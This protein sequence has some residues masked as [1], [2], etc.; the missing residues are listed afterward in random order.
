MLNNWINSTATQMLSKNNQFI[1]NTLTTKTQKNAYNLYYELKNVH[2]LYF[3]DKKINMFLVSV[4]LPYG[5]TIKQV[6]L[7][8]MYLEYLN[9]SYKFLRLIHNLPIRKV[10]TH[11]V[12]RKTQWV[13]TLCINYCMKTIPLFK[14]L[15]LPHSRIK[16]LF[17]C[18]FINS[19]WFAN[20]WKD[21][22]S[23][24]RTRV[25]SVAKNSFIKWKYDLVGLQQG[26]AILFTTK[27]K[28][29]KH[30]RRKAV[31]LKNTYNVGF[32]YGFSL[33]YTKKI[34]SNLQKK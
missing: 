20:W 3:F 28:K 13:S 2:S 26:R 34:L 6:F 22:F 19:V 24:Y 33:V 9:K 30:N 15:K 4:F 17:F 12:S 10:R 8:K 29:A 5:V 18:E 1:I 31:V 16:L 25:K 7:Y 27:K 11:S 32:N 21:W 23:S 14:Q